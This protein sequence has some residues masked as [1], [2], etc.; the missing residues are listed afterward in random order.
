V[1]EMR[2]KENEGNN[3]APKM[4]FFKMRKAYAGAEAGTGKNCCVR[5]NR[6]EHELFAAK[7][8]PETQKTVF[9]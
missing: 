8:R 4:P 6:M 3:I 5:Q 1:D 9:G 2:R 7:R